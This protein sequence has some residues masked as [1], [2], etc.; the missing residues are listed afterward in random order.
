VIDPV[1]HGVL[2]LAVALAIV[3]VHGFFFTTDDKVAL[4]TVPIRLGRFV[5]WC[6]VVAGVLI[7]AEHT[8]ASI[9]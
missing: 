2:F 9:H 4:R 5:F 3:L 6:A 1:V 7:V 8:V